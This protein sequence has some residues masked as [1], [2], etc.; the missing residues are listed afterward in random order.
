MSDKRRLVQ[1]AQTKYRDGSEE[2]HSRGT[3]IP[4]AMNVRD[5][6]GVRFSVQPIPH[7]IVEVDDNGAETVY[8]LTAE[9]LE[10]LIKSNQEGNEGSSPLTYRDIIREDVNAQ[11]SF[12]DEVQLKNHDIGEE[13][14]KL[15]PLEPGGHAPKVGYLETKLANGSI[16]N[17][18]ASAPDTE[19]IVSQAAMDAAKDR[20]NPPP[21]V[22]ENDYA[23]IR[24]D[25]MPPVSTPEF[26]D[27]PMLTDSVPHKNSSVTRVARKIPGGTAK[28]PSKAVPVAAPQPYSIPRNRPAVSM[29]I[30][31]EEIQEEPEDLD[32]EPDPGLGPKR[33]ASYAVQ[34]RAT[35]VEVPPE[36]LI[37]PAMMLESMKET[38]PPPELGGVDPFE[39]DGGVARTSVPSGTLG[40]YSNLK[41]KPMQIARVRVRFIGSFGKLAVPYNV[42]FRYDYL[43]V[44]L[45]YNPDGMFYEP[46][47]VA[48]GQHIEVQWHGRIFMCFSGPYFIMPDQ[49]TA[50]T[51]FLIDEN[52]TL[53]VQN[54][55]A[56][57]KAQ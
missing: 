8:K 31:N 10:A 41:T 17:E 9:N 55:R 43:L 26:V 27:Q 52:E 34:L 22:I 50:V 29:L 53:E 14:T 48:N 51:L 13:V 47:D 2:G 20:I 54:E 38:P 30:P 40:A 4:K 11:R 45:Q 42:V 12:L 56:T 21:P 15:M 6:S 19:E 46:P 7:N 49:Q 18:D 33:L 44:M 35:D 5:G 25:T 28:G 57:G 24:P 23:P 37:K 1:E 32:K 16:R 39:Q 3:I 36:P